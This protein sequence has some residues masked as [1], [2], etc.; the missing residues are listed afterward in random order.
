MYFDLPPLLI[1][2]IFCV[3]WSNTSS[4]ELTPVKI[5]TIILLKMIWIE[6][7]SKLFIFMPS[8]YCLAINSVFYVKQFINLNI[9]FDFVFKG[10][11]SIH[12]VVRGTKTFTQI[13]CYNIML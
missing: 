8:C 13:K 1:L 9:Y 10:V 5:D 12:I 6:Y 11:N 2:T 7:I 4:K 3:I